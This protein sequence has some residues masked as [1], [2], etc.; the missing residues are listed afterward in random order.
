MTNL[1]VQPQSRQCQFGAQFQFAFQNDCKVFQTD[2]TKKS[3]TGDQFTVRI[4]YRLEL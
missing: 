3:E 2:Q 1:E 4:K